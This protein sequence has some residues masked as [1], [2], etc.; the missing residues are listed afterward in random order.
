MENPFDILL[1]AIMEG[2]EKHPAIEYVESQDIRPIMEGIATL[3]VGLVDGR[4]I[5]VNLDMDEVG[6]EDEITW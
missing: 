6:E 1:T 2:L 5:M 3:S 4:N